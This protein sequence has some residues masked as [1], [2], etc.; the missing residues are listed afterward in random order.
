M[1]KMTKADEMRAIV[2]KRQEEYNRERPDQLYNELLEKIE[3]Y[4]NERQKKFIY[5]LYSDDNGAIIEE[6]T[7]KLRKEGF[8]IKKDFAGILTISWH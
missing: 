6:V 4:S 3:T 8:E 5:A 7:A 1:N 2:E